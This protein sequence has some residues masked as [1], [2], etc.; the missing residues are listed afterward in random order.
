MHLIRTSNVDES[1]VDNFFTSPPSVSDDQV[2]NEIFALQKVCTNVKEQAFLNVHLDLP[3]N[4]A[5]LFN[6][7]SDLYEGEGRLDKVAGFQM[8]CFDWHFQDM[9]ND[10]T[11]SELF[12]AIEEEDLARAKFL[13]SK[14][15]NIDVKTAVNRTPFHLAC[16]KGNLDL[17][18]LLLDKGAKIN[19]KEAYAG[20]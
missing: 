1:E 19:E 9:V 20:W 3:K 7:D 6:S 5:L 15:S 8:R 14:G 12:V 2:T 17:A 16:Q 4:Y 18:K 11:K 10:L 13:I